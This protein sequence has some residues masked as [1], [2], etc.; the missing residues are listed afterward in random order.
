MMI[1]KR[2]VRLFYF[3]TVVS[4]CAFMSGNWIFFWLHFMTYGQLG[5]ID[6]LAFAFGLLMEIPTGAISDSVGKRKTLLMAMGS[7]AIAWTVMGF[8]TG[9]PSLTAGFLVAQVGW[10][11][12]SGAAEALVYDSLKQDGQ[13]ARFERIIANSHVISLV[14]LVIATL[15]GGLMYHWHFRLPHLAWGMAYVV[16]FVAAWGLIEPAVDSQTFSLA[17]YRRQLAQGYHQLRQP[18]LRPYF[19][20]IF[21][22]LGLAYLYNFGLIQPALATSFGFFADEQAVIYPIL[23]LSAAGLIHYMPFLRR[24]ISDWRAMQGIALLMAAA[25]ALAALPLGYGG[26][27]V[28]LILRALG[29]LAMPWMSVI[30]NQAID[31]EARATTLSTLALLGKLPYVIAA[32]LA[33]VLIERGH[34]DWFVLGTALVVLAIV[35]LTQ[36]RWPRASRRI[37]PLPAYPGD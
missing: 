16:G 22:T 33:G 35:T 18:A 11:F 3:L 24:H 19:P 1:A 6:S 34:L 8:G 21:G 23:A 25:F 9:I 2:N 17:A 20:L 26:F 15:I 36:V 5:L 4:A 10:A 29:G 14:T 37:A 31:S 28:L 30:V 12:Y 7:S 32:T 13:E 27:G